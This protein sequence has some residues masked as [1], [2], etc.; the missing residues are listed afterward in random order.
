MIQPEIE[1]PWFN[2]DLVYV[3]SGV[4]WVPATVT[5][6][7]K[8]GPK[9]VFEDG[10]VMLMRHR[11]APKCMQRV[12]HL[13]N[14]DIE[15]NSDEPKDR[16][17]AV[18]DDGTTSEETEAV[19]NL[20][21]DKRETV[22]QKHEEHAACLGRPLS[23]SSE[24]QVVAAKCVSLRF[25]GVSWDKHAQK[26][27]AEISIDGK[28]T[29]LGTIDDEETATRK[30]DKHTARLHK[31]IN[32]PS[33]GQ[34]KAVKCVSS[35]F[36][37]VYWDKHAQ[38]WTARISIEGKLIHLGN[39][40]DEETSAQKYDEHAARLGRPL[41][42][43]SMGQARAAKT[44]S[45]FRGVSWDKQRQKWV[46]F[47]KIDGKNKYL[48]TSDH[49]KTAAGKYDEHAA[50]LGRPLNFPSE[51]QAQATMG[52]S[53][54]FRGVCWHTPTQK[55]IANI[56]I[57]GKLTRLGY[58][59]DEETAARKY[60]EHTA[61]LGGAVNC[62]S[63]EKL[64][65]QAILTSNWV[66]ER[67]LL[68]R[69]RD[70]AIWLLEHERSC[71]SEMAL[72]RDEA[73]QNLARESSRAEK[74]HSMVRPLESTQC[75]LKQVTLKVKEALIESSVPSK[76]K[77]SCRALSLDEDNS[78]AAMKKGPKVP[79]VRSE[80]LG[81]SKQMQNE[82]LKTGAVPQKYLWI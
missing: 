18:V 65:A 44:T 55:W 39:F 2:G 13:V 52:K 42:F 58:F 28:S 81:L 63:E 73:L 21:E 64:Q 47:I 43:P 54:M 41:N 71:R 33:E 37:G 59:D 62:P 66:H 11:D 45:K 61:R 19:A 82:G 20:V 9:V 29:Y 68:V 4:Q 25:R 50:R 38:K 48:G 72:E 49:E 1:Q 75:D 24:G 35:R 23:I 57:D 70:N 22:A 3:L 6:V 56:R 36:R 5:E 67:E 51:G 27:K 79:W 40:D 69:E 77:R 26:R 14:W 34:V 53:S 80:G 12:S 10:S 30:L 7:L 15:R 8:S 78:W 74:Q 32:F 46:A 76:R 31:T 60:D 17:E 16:A